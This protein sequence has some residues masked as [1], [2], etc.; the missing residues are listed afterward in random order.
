MDGVKGVPLRRLQAKASI[1]SRSS[2]EG[3]TLATPLPDWLAQKI[4][5]DGTSDEGLDRIADMLQK[6]YASAVAKGAGRGQLDALLNIADRACCALKRP[7][8]WLRMAVKSDWRV[9]SPGEW[10]PTLKNREKADD[11]KP[12][13]RKVS[14]ADEAGGPIAVVTS[15]EPTTPTVIDDSVKPRKRLLKATTK[16]LPELKDRKWIIQF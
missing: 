3:P 2:P 15:P 8:G 7:Y 10:V 14:F 16:D 6:V 13:R 12:V 4:E 1:D 5:Q 11:V 9:G